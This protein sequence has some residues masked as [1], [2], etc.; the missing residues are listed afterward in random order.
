[1]ARR[2]LKGT[3]GTIFPTDKSAA[4]LCRCS[5]TLIIE[6]DD[7]LQTAD[8]SGDSKSVVVGDGWAECW[9]TVTPAPPMTI[10]RLGTHADKA[11]SFTLQLEDD[12]G[13]IDFQF[14]GGVDVR[15]ANGPRPTR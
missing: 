6:T 3:S 8:G 12:D 1:M 7:E 15:G 11:G 4:A 14:V 9:G 2:T 10:G 5:Y 13:W